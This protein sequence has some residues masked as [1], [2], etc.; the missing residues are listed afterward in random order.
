MQIQVIS[1]FFLACSHI[2]LLLLGFSGLSSLSLSVLA[3]ALMSAAQKSLALWY[4][5]YLFV[6]SDVRKQLSVKSSSP[7]RLWPLS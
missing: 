5:S 6:P 4:F 7:N 1:D 3:A 2:S